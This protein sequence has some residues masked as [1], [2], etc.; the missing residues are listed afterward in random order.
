MEEDWID[1]YWILYDCLW[2]VEGAVTQRLVDLRRNL[3]SSSF[4]HIVGEADETLEQ[5]HQ[6]RTSII[7]SIFRV[8]GVMTPSASLLEALASTLLAWDEDL[9]S[10]LLRQDTLHVSLI[11]FKGIRSNRLSIAVIE[12]AYTSSYPKLRESATRAYGILRIGHEIFQ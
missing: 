9:D 2:A 1:A 8:P 7:I 11:D 6:T 3:G 12:P 5:L 10:F 4:D